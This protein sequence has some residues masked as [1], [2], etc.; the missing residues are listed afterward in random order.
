MFL[1]LTEAGRAYLAQPFPPICYDVL[2]SA[3]VDGFGD[4]G[5]RAYIDGRRVSLAEYRDL[6]SGPGVR[7][8]SFTTCTLPCGTRRQF[9][10]VAIV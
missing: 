7:F 10:K 3:P 1:D 2:L 4:R 8:D 9:R 5:I 6:C